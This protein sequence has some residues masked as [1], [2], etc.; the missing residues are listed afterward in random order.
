MASTSGQPTLD[1]ASINLKLFRESLVKDLQELVTKADGK[2]KNK[3]LVLDPALAG[4][5]G[6]VV[7]ISLLKESGI[8]NIFYLAPEQLVT[9][10]RNVIYICRPK[11]KFMKWIAQHINSHKARGQKKNY[12]INFVP[13]RRLMCER[14]LEE[15]GVW[16]DVEMGIGEYKLDLIPF[17]SD[18]LSMEMPL[19]FKE[20]SLEGDKTPLF[21]VARGLM[22]LQFLFGIIPNII[23][24]GVNSQ[25][26]AEMLFRMRREL[27]SKEQ[28]IIPEIDT[29]I[30]L[31]RECDL[32]TPMCTQ[33]TYEGLIDEVFGIFNASVDLPAEMVI[34][35]KAQEKEVVP[36]GKKVK[37]S[38]N[39]NDKLFRDIRDVN[40][41][42]VGPHL[43]QKAK[44]IDEYYK[45]RHAAKT[46]TDLRDFMKRLAAFQKEHQ[47]LRIHTNIAESVLGVTR[48]PSFRT[49][50]EA[51][52]NLLAL[53]ETE[54]SMQYIEECINKQEPLVK[55]LRLMC[56][57]SLTNNGIKDKNYNFLRREILQTYGFKYMFTLDN[58]SKLGML[59]VSSARVNLYQRLKKDMNLII[60]E[61]NEQDPTDIA[62]VYSGYAPV[63]IRLVEKATQAPSPS[64][65]L[66]DTNTNNKHQPEG[67]TKINI[68]NQEQDIFQGWGDS[69]IDNIVSI[70]SG[71]PSFHAR[72][73]LPKG[74]SNPEN[75]GSVRKVVMVFFVGGCTYTEI[76]ALRFLKHKN[77]D[78]DFIIGTTRL[79][80]GNTLIESLIEKF[81]K[82]DILS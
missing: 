13:K 71:G 81:G 2:E 58:L 63:S 14:T 55:V 52:Q 53:Q 38:L 46:V 75:K 54:F 15:E 1:D 73:N 37:T 18:I 23:G 11:V 48:D 78:L 21:Y 62:Y 59:K 33:L 12:Y 6:L 82:E 29:L 19:S 60:E 40:F 76:S 34:D 66:D 67:V 4:P 69:R 16:D 35:P 17:D 47:F 28:L 74:L 42:V 5:L 80:N 68:N 79:L 44:I 31:D 77:P 22:K 30:L 64:S 70:C 56:L 50:L 27:A 26:V 41:S 9:E 36:P 32:V 51:E 20:C 57:Y 8:D 10:A 24:K 45:E 3:T 7:E 39:S 49:R 25:F 72:Q 43:N 61:M 65:L